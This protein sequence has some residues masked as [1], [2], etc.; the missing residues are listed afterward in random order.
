MDNPTHQVAATERHICRLWAVRT[1]ALHQA[2]RESVRALRRERDE[3]EEWGS[4][5]DADDYRDQVCN[6]PR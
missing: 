5:R 3:A 6:E 4:M 1:P 2:I